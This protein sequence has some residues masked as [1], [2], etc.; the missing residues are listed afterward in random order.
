MFHV[1][2]VP[3][4]C[5]NLRIR[6]VSEAAHISPGPLCFTPHQSLIDFRSLS[7]F[8]GA[9]LFLQAHFLW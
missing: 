3:W 4:E 7:A 5:E 2:L 8:R 6:K 1:K 9:S